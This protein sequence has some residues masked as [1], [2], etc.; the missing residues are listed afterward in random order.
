MKLINLNITKL[1]FG[2]AHQKA[3]QQV[4]ILDNKNKQLMRMITQP[5]DHVSDFTQKYINQVDLAREEMISIIDKACDNMKLQINNFKSSCEARIREEAN[6]FTRIQK[7]VD[8]IIKTWRE[9]L[10]ELSV[11]E[12]V[13]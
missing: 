1:D 10:N 13:V 11:K 5:E 7:S 6:S 12:G 3:K 9:K 4:D 2:P 8:T